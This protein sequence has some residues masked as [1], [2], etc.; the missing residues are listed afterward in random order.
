MKRKSISTTDELIKSLNSLKRSLLQYKNSLN[1]LV[2]K[3]NFP[4]KEYIKSKSQSLRDY[5]NADR[6]L[7]STSLNLFDKV[8]NRFI[9]EWESKKQIIDRCTELTKSSDNNIIRFAASVLALATGYVAFFGALRA[10]VHKAI[11]SKISLPKEL[12]SFRVKEKR[13]IIWLIITIIPIVLSFFIFPNW[14]TLALAVVGLLLFLIEKFHFSTKEHVGSNLPG[15]IAS[16]IIIEI[17]NL[18]NR[19]NKI[20]AFSTIIENTKIYW[21]PIIYEVLEKLENNKEVERNV[22][23]NMT[24]EIILIYSEFNKTST[25]ALRY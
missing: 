17:D 4:K 25:L 6:L 18:Q 24:Q 22:L 20:D 15:D 11:F 21:P 7:I 8:N 5:R 3:A 12:E 23:T 10:N 14:I 9:D 2:N 13:S 1:D 16:D 19:I